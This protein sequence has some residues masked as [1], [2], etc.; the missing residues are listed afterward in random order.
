[1][2]LLSPWLLLPFGAAAV[3]AFAVPAGTRPAVIGAVET[4]V[5]VLVVVGARWRYSRVW[6]DRSVQLADL[7][8]YPVKSGAGISMTAWPLDER[9]LRLD[10]S[11][12]VVRADTGA[13]LTQRQIPAL[14]LLRPALGDDLLTLRT[15][16]GTVTVPMDGDGP[17]RTVQV[18]EH[19]GAARDCG[20]RA[21]ELVSEL[22]GLPARLVGLDPGHDRRAEPGYAGAGV[23]VGF[24]DGYPLLV[25]SQASLDALNA[26]LP[27]PLPM[28]R[29]RPNL[30]LTGTEPFAEDGWTRI[31]VGAIPIDI[32]KP[33]TRCAIT[34]VDQ[35]TGRRAG[36]E[37][38]RALG[39]FR[40]GP[41]G[42]QFGQ[43]AVHRAPGMLRV[44]DPVQP[45]RVG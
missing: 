40:R 31:E 39:T 41:K 32:V 37:P 16:H 22:V 34:T 20:D 36:A 3:R 12:M 30:V 18:W 10:R 29:F 42:V 35:D 6:H 8:I 24:S 4:A 19:I 5:S 7:L 28:N 9:G 45:T 17:A 15:P 1:M 13:F 21:A 43:N 26:R 25:I 14:A 11:F 38:L 27:Q 33:C 44:G 2:G 23:P